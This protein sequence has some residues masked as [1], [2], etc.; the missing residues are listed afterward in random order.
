MDL[1]ETIK[2]AAREVFS[3]LGPGYSEQVYES[4]L[5]VEMYTRFYSCRRQV[6]CPISYK[7]QI[8]GYGLIDMVVGDI[9]LEIKTVQ[10]ISNKEEIQLRKY[11]LGTG[12][13]HGILLNFGPSAEEVEIVDVKANNT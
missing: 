5:E 8:V 12:L 11:L 3:V 6:T 2:E 13:E 4:A 1:L 9:V 10:K 7:N